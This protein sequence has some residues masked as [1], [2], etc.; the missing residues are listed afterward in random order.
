MSDRLPPRR[1]GDAAIR[2]AM[3]ALEHDAII[4]RAARADENAVLADHVAAILDERGHDCPARVGI[5]EH[6]CRQRRTGNQQ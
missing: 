3:P 1:V 5:A 2:G 6:E 4:R